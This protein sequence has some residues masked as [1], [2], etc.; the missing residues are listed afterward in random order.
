MDEF[1]IWATSAAG[2]VGALLLFFLWNLACAPYRIERDENR[3]LRKKISELE[4]KVEER[5]LSPD[6]A[7]ADA[8][9]FLEAELEADRRIAHQAIVHG[10]RLQ[11]F[12]VWA[13]RLEL[14][15]DAGYEALPS[16]LWADYRMEL[17]TI[18]GNE[19][20]RV[21][22]K[23]GYAAVPYS[24]VHFNKRELDEALPQL[25]QLVNPTAAHASQSPQAP[26]RRTPPRTRPG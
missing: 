19:Y 26:E 11:L 2:A 1:G 21:V 8:Y 3:R 15:N 5:P 22:A 10:A 9:R 7:L 16:D 4:A 25:A 18:H 17:A 20:G 23:R 13:V 24:R 6:L 14:G 12:H